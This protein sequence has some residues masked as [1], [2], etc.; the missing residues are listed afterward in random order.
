MTSK[1]IISKLISFFKLSL[2]V[3]LAGT[4][5]NAFAEYYVVYS[6]V[7][8]GGGS[9]GRPSCNSPC[10]SCHTYRYKKHKTYV[11]KRH[12]RYDMETY[13]VWP[14]YAGT[15]SVP[16]CGTG[17]CM[18]WDPGYCRTMDCQDFYVPPQYIVNYSDPN[19]GPSMDMRT[20]D[21]F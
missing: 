6:V 5:T 19:T 17:G 13:Y 1:I 3:I 20:T 12:S 7:E 21:D 11:H 10:K 2:I 14:M 9:C 16:T 8:L 18:K 4:M 15:L